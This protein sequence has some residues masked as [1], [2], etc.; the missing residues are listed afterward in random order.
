MG[1]GSVGITESREHRRMVTPTITII[2]PAYNEEAVLP[3]AFARLDALARRG[4]TDGCRYEL[5]IVDDG[6]TDGTRDLILNHAA[7]RDNVDYVFLSRNF[8]KEDAMLAGLDRADGDAAVIVDADLQDPPELIPDMVKLWRE[9]YDDVYAR[10]R[11]RAG[12]SRLKRL[13]AHWYYRL[14]AAM[15]PVT[16]QPDTGDF[17]L[18]D[19]RCVLALRRLREA[20]R[21]TKALFSWIGFRKKEF[22]YDRDA[23]VAG[24]TKW[25]WP[26]LVRLALD[27]ITS[28]TTAPLRVASY[29]GILVSILA[30]GYAAYIVARTLTLGVDV[31]G[32]AS[33]LVAVLLLG[34]LQLLALGVIGEY[35]GRMFTEVKRRPDYL[36]E[37]ESTAHGAGLRGD[38][39]GGCGDG[40]GGCGDA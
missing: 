2:M 3:A 30:S 8:G 23:R 18:L 37:E 17:R 5:L 13:T 29:V 19:R 27:G 32:Y 11:S 1:R 34:G 7:K 20:N 26:K 14:L 38:G 15:S 39:N 24:A 10:R 25:N 22:L 12:E 33:L 35:L 28:F 16:I 6:S 21:N 40:N 4:P 31:P 36:V 9:G